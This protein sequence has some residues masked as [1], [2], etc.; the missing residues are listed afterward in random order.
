ME[1]Q[2]SL[3]M[4]RREK[5]LTSKEVAVRLGISPDTVNE[6]ARKR[7]LKGFKKGRQWRFHLH[8]VSLFEKTFRKVA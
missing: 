5:L 4:T 3:K 2:K 8:D 6:F 1:K 7:I